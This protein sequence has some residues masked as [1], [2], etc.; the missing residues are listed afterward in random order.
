LSQRTLG[1]LPVN[2]IAGIVNG[3]AGALLP[4]SV[5]IGIVSGPAG[6]LLPARVIIG[7]VSGPAGAVLP[8]SV[9]VGIASEWV[10]PTSSRDAAPAVPT[11]A[12]PA[13][14]SA[15]SLG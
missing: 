4:A 7:I 6:A 1:A 14:R 10:G 11:M 2:V 5:I 8:A 3:P 12:T 13:I 15:R 9:I